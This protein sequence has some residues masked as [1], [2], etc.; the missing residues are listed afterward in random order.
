MLFRRRSRDELHEARVADLKE[1]YEA[2]H[3]EMMRLVDM[4]AEQV[5]YLRAQLGRPFI[6]AQHPG[7]NPAQQ[8]P[9]SGFDLDVPKHVGEEEEDLRALHEAGFLDELELAK[10][11]SEQLGTPVTTD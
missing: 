3:R 9:V 1:A 6:A 8:L 11:L 5:E 2:R 10:A 4:L 7:T